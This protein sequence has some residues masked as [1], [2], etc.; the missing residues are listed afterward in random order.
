MFICILTTV[1]LAHNLNFRNFT[2]D[3]C[4]LRQL[5]QGQVNLFITNVVSGL[6]SFLP[7]ELLLLGCEFATSPSDGF[8]VMET[9]DGPIL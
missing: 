6:P 1:S 5:S 3:A 2:D 9:M 7:L 4:Y 8:F